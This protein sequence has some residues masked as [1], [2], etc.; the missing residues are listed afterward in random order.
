MT[1]ASVLALPDF[2]LPFTMETYAFDIAMGA[3]QT[4]QGHPFVFFSKPFFP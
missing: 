3:V 1:A 2:S 4:Q